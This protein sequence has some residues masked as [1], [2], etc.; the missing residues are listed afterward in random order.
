MARAL[1]I[2][3]ASAWLAA[4]GEPGPLAALEPG[5]RGRVVRVIDGDALVLDTGLSVRLVGIEAPAPA[6]RDRRGQPYADESRRLLEDLVIGREVRLYYPGLT[7]DRYDRALAHIETADALGP[8]LWV[9]EA[10]VRRGGARARAY[11]D[12]AA[13]GDL[14][15]AAETEA[16]AAAQGM[17]SK[18][19]YA[20]PKAADIAPGTRGFAIVSAQ[21][22]RAGSADRPGAVCTLEL[23][24][25][26]LVVDVD[27]AAASACRSGAGPRR[28]RGY[29][30]EGRMELTHAFNFET[31]EPFD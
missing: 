25:A 19:A 4:C 16:R 14:L 7:R 13:L 17:W 5:E 26:A 27:A 6:R 28:I 31:A 23:E 30:S 22:A 21:V 29:V 9:N 3:I 18:G 20:I 10:M 8:R 15:L 1:S 11:P 24:D 2:L 12:T